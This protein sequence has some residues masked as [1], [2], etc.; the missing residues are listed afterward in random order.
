MVSLPT[1]LVAAALMMP[2]EVEVVKFTAEWCAP[3]RE[4]EPVLHDLS[5]QG[6]RVTRVDVDQQTKLARQY[7]V[8]SVPT[9]LLV[10]NGRIVDRIDGAVTREQIAARIRAATEGVDGRRSTRTTENADAHRSIAS[11][12]RNT[13]R[14]ASAG[15]SPL[16]HSP[17]G[18]AV[19]RNS[20]TRSPHSQSLD[21]T[22]Q[23]ARHATVRLRVED[24]RGQSFGTGTIVHVHDHDALVLT[25]GHIFRESQGKGKITVDLV[26][27]ASDRQVA[28][29]LIRYDLE[30]DLA[31]VG[32]RVS[33]TVR[34]VPIAGPGYHVATAQRLFSVGCDRGR[35]PSVMRGKLKA[36]N[37]Y[38]GPENLVVS[39]RPID[40][41]SGGGLFTYDG[42]LV[43]V[44][45]AADQEID[46]G[47]YAAF[48]SIHRHLD[49][50]D[51][52]FVYRNPDSLSPSSQLVSTGP[53][54][55]RQNP[56]RKKPSRFD[57]T[58]GNDVALAGFNQARDSS[59][60]SNARSHSPRELNAQQRLAELLPESQATTRGLATAAEGDEPENAEII[61]IIRPKNR[62]N[63]SSEVV[64]LDRP[65]RDF[66]RTLNREHE[67]QQ[68]RQ[69]TQVRRTR[70][71]RNGTRAAKSRVSAHPSNRWR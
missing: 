10:A 65:S 29:Q 7:Q 36:V 59:R 30:R 66:L 62:P 24:E 3:C 8:T 47:L 22:E 14:N 33:H 26:S 68:S 28:G 20:V 54:P 60:R 23:L 55:R 56:L 27:P 34:A 57:D 51:L 31:L 5:Q 38:L 2:G 53:A 39:G 25:C 52:A 4:M 50:A 69:A 15:N 13:T 44:C 42:R 16:G 32:I 43:G 6:Y 37:K 40:G 1:W 46:E 70:E 63:G 19:A 18:N 64:V 12:S 9:L 48:A 11:A 45:N 17:Q 67:R 41:R 49:D 35:A 61:C 71:A 58:P 21:A